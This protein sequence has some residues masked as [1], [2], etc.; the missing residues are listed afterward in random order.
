MLRQQ[1]A[2]GQQAQRGYILLSA[3]MLILILSL[4]GMTSLFLAGQDVP[5]ISA[6]KEETAAQQLADAAA[7]LVISWFHD[8]GAAPASMAELLAK[9]QGD[10]ATGP[11]FF[12]AA[13]S[14][15]FV[16]TAERPDILLDAANPTDHNMLNSSPSGFP[17]SLRGLGRL[18]KLK[19]YGPL[20]P[21]LLGTVE[22]TAAT[23]DQK[24]MSRTVQIQLGALTIPAVRA[25]VQVGGGLGTLHPGGESPVRVHWGD[26]RIVG[27]LVVKKIEQVVMKTTSASVT[28][29]PYDSAE[30][31]L[32]RWSDYWIGGDL[33][34]TAPP[35]GQSVHP[36]A[37]SN[38]HLYQMPA[39]GVRLDQWE[40]D[41]MKKAAV[42]HG[43]YYR[44]DRQGL[45]H[46][47][48]APEDDQGVAPS[49]VLISRGVGDH[50]GLV[51]IDT[52]DGAPPRA[53]N[54]GTLVMEAD[55]LECLLVVQGHVVLK[56]SGGGRSVP[57]LS[58]ALEGTNSLGTRIP[59]QL[60]GIHLQGL[61]WAAG[62]V[63]IERPMR[64]FGAVMIGESVVAAASGASIEIW[65]NADLAQGL[66]RGLPV[67]Y[68]VPGTWRLL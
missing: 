66:F 42:R 19:L 10:A 54:L 41:V 11:S 24:P 16:G 3:L 23:T 45:L 44:L 62:M 63:T 4:F 28:A 37:P 47:P 18:T 34:V 39:P 29:L 36:M 1:T 14:S 5:G 52:L 68:R 9:R 48:E 58:P 50:R 12:D 61:L 46:A 6:M 40:Y 51:F 26:Q 60:S 65:Y 30:Q 59:V 49:E 64:L 15:Q 8:S 2:E 13:R 31:A 38:V 17:A 20:R 32:D 33:T 35:P 22:V 67:V 55:Y 43:T 25:P 57:A 27:N 56:P 21:G 7:E 53:D